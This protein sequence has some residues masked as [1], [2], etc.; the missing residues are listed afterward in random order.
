MSKKKDY[1]KMYLAEKKKRRSVETELAKRSVVDALYLREKGKTWKQVGKKLK[2]SESTIRLRTQRHFTKAKT[3]KVNPVLK[4]RMTKEKS[5]AI[6]KMN[7]YVAELLKK[8][9]MPHMKAD[10]MDYIRSHRS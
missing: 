2:V 4:G 5:D 10:V 3:G 9:G 8:E 1:K 7:V 6:R